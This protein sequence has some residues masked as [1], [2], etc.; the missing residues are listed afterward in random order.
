[1]K[2]NI[3]WVLKQQGLPLNCR[4]ISSDALKDIDIFIHTAYDRI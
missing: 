4:L 1:M 3:W 2:K